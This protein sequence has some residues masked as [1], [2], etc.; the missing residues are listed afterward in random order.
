MFAQTDD[1]LI[2]RLRAPTDRAWNEYE[3][4]PAALTPGLR[5][6]EAQLRALIEEAAP[7]DL[8]LPHLRGG[9][10]GELTYPRVSGRLRRDLLVRE[11]RHP[12]V[13]A[14][15]CDGDVGALRVMVSLVDFAIGRAARE[16]AGGAVFR[17]GVHARA[18]WLD[19]LDEG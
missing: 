18:T 15:F 13:T 6:G 8:T 17:D 16:R 12:I 2:D 11:H 5:P 4:S 14:G 7:P 9:G 1:A 10:W 3:W 19:E